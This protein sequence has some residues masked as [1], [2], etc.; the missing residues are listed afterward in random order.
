MNEQLLLE[1][2]RDVLARLED[3]IIF[4]LI[5]RAQFCVNAIVYKRGAFRAEIG[6]ESLAGYMLRETERTHARVRRYTS[7]DEHPFFTDLPDP[8]LPLLR[9]DENPL[10]T[11][12]INF[13]DP[14]RRMY[15]TEMIPFLCRPGDDSQYGSSAV[16]D[17]ACLQALSK[18]IHYGKFVV[19]SKYQARPAFFRP[20]MAARDTG[21]LMAGITN[22]EVEAQVLERVGE[23]ARTYG[24]GVEPHGSLPKISPERVVQAYRK[25]IIP[26]TKEVQVAY[27]LQRPCD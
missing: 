4:A 13:N 18:R 5:E 16:C 27:L 11:N 10:R 25:W 23:K 8:V 24:Y 14:I 22:E 15:E 20:L 19:E 2:I 3:T 7:P 21:G 9:Y 1:N 26:M 6:E 12:T 17:V